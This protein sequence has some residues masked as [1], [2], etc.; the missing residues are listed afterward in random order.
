[1]SVVPAVTCAAG[2]ARARVTA[3]KGVRA[4]GVAVPRAVWRAVAGAEV[5]EVGAVEDRR[6]AAPEG[7]VAEAAAAAITAVEVASA[8]VAG[9]AAS[10]PASRAEAAEQA[11]PSAEMAVA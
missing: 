8:V 11:A 9:W 3:G 2:T 1:M 10:S 7:S 4:A 5:T 6:M